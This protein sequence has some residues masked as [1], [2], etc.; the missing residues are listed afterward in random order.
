[1]RL[2]TSQRVAALER[3]VVVLQETTKLLHKLLKQQRQL[4]S[5]Y[6]TQKVT[7]ANS[8]DGGN[9]NVRPEDALYTFMCK[10]RFERMEK[11]IRK[12]RESSTHSGPGLK[13]G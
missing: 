11:D 9:G 5:D 6:I 10:R 1:M 3:E 7:A 4:I 8:G 13:A 2:T 12:L